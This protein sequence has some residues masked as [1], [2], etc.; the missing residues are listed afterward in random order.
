MK[1]IACFALVVPDYD[2]AIEY[3]TQVI[4]LELIEDTRQ[5]QSKRWVLVAPSQNS[6]TA[7]LLA[8]ADNATQKQAIGNQSGGRVFIIYH[9]NNFERDYL[10]MRSAGVVF[11]EEPRREPYGI[12]A[13]F[14]DRY[15]NR[16]DLLE[17]GG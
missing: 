5:T 14:Q 4:G 15:G 3:Y 8:R 10:R 2:E 13:V 9:T 11:E 1:K 16:W 17:P 7:I 12:V 6:E